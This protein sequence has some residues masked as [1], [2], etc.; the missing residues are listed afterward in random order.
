ME[1]R[2]ET[3]FCLYSDWDKT[4]DKGFNMIEL[5]DPDWKRNP[6]VDFDQIVSETEEER[7]DREFN[8]YIDNQ[9]ELDWVEKFR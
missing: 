4:A 2:R 7:R 9:D 8:E 6:E 5:P 1:N 3:T